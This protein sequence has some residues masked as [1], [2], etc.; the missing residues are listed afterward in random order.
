[1]FIQSQPDDSGARYKSFKLPKGNGQYRTVYKVLDGNWNA[2]LKGYLPYLDRR[3]KELDTLKVNYAFVKGRNCVLNALQH[4]G[5]NYTM[6]FDLKSFF[7]SVTTEHV[8]SLLDNEILDDCFV[9]GA[10][11]QGI[12]T[13]PVICNIAFLHCDSLINNALSLIS[14]EFKYTRYA[15]DLIISFD[16]LSDATKIGFV[17]RQIVERNGF[18]L[19]E[20]K[21]KL[22]SVS[23]GRVIVTGVAIDRKGIYPTRKIK[24]KIRAAIHQNNNTSLKGLE[25]WAKCNLPNEVAK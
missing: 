17:V 22:Q 15:D 13:S 25:E 5:Y 7:D 11:R 10:P 20:K 19:N 18:S 1:M 12:P 2:R 8:S 14:I 23:N 3:L 21:T 9:E 16:K 24:K 6:N 4:V